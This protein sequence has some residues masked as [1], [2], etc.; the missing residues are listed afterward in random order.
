MPI[1]DAFV[2]GVAAVLGIAIIVGAAG[3]RSWLLERRGARSLVAALGLPVARVVL[4]IIGIALIALGALIGLG[5]RL[6]WL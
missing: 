2:G 4:G 1:Q 3:R 6:N 5:W